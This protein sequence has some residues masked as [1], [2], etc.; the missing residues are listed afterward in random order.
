MSIEKFQVLAEK[1]VENPWL[2]ENEQEEKIIQLADLCRF[3]ACYKPGIH[4]KEVRNH[5]INVV[6]DDGI[7]KGILF[8]D[9]KALA[10][11]TSHASGLNSFALEAYKAQAKVRELWMVFIEDRLDREEDQ[12][13]SFLEKTSMGTVY[14]KIFYFDFFQSIVHTLK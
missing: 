3:I 9:S 6:E 5:Q 10:Q 12:L 1:I 2:A 11:R 8:C 7:R 14:D 13:H 4:I